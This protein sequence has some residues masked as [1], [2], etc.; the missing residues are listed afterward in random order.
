MEF[1]PID[2]EDVLWSPVDVLPHDELLDV[3]LRLSFRGPPRANT[4]PHSV[5]A[6]SDVDLMEL[7]EFFRL[8]AVD[9]A[10]ATCGGH[11]TDHEREIHDYPHPSRRIHS[12]HTCA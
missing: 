1:Q 10:L 7:E 5:E 6:C 12:L 4:A 2:N 8:E 9:S 3:E 11:Q